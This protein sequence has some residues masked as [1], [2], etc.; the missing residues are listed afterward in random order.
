MNH[1]SQSL[2]L[3]SYLPSVRGRLESW[4]EGDFARRLWAKDP[5]LWF[6]EPRPELTDRLGW[7]TLHET[8]RDK[9]PKLRA[10]ADGAK[11][12]GFRHAVLLGMGGSS[13]APEVYQR[14][15]GNAPG[16]P[17][18][19]VLDSTHPDAVRAVGDRIDPAQTI[20]VVSSKSGG[21]LE[22][23][24]GFRYFWSL[25]VDR[26]ETP[27]NHFV[28]VTDPGSSLE[29]LATERGFRAVFHAPSDVGGR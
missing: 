4:D 26:T 20:F 2:E 28:A 7:L 17:E 22:T 9:L 12:D 1:E 10:L 16:Y 25:V 11:D 23:M 27:G 15:F 8:M 21:T 29:A 14:T 24:S 19:L 6:A 13:L 5:T 3:G 18:L